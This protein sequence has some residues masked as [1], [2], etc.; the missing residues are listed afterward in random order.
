MLGRLR[1]SLARPLGRC[2]AKAR[3]FSTNASVEVK[4]WNSS[5]KAL[6]FG[7][8]ATAAGLGL[9]ALINTESSVAHASG[10]ELHP[11]EY[12]WWHQRDYG[13]LDHAA[14][15]RGFEV[16]RQVCATCHSLD[17]IK[18]RNLV[19]VTHTLPQVKMMAEQQ[20]VQDG[21]NDKG[22]MFMRPGQLGDGFKRP[23]PNDEFGRYANNGALPPDL[24]LI[25]KARQPNHRGEDYIFALLTGYRDPPAGVNLRQG[26]TTTR[27]SRVAPSACPLLCSTV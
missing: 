20:E 4:S 5:K 1:Q 7:A 3:T 9:G 12:D 10:A 16:Y 26:L 22:E 11:A 14:I 6:A 15:R 2:S 25:R 8:A 24:S 18:W 27:T 19:G 13:A 21:P 17:F 23:Y